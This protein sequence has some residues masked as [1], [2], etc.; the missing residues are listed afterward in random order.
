MDGTNTKVV[1]K[2]GILAYYLGMAT[3]TNVTIVIREGT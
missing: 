2:T 3:P 1:S